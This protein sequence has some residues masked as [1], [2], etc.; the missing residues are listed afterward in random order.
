MKP[1]T[2]QT[3]SQ[4]SEPRTSAQRLRLSRVRQA[5]VTS[6][7]VMGIVASM[8]GLGMLDRAAMVLLEALIGLQML[9]FVAMVRLGF[10][11]KLRDPS[12]TAAQ[13]VG[14]S[15]VLLL[16][17]YFATYD[18]RAIMLMLILLVFAFAS[19]RYGVAGL[20]RLSGLLL[21]LVAIEQTA[22][23]VLRADPIS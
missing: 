6:V 16:G 4:P 12:M 19:Y 21:L 11:L 7:P 5:V 3:D 2:V 14:A 23:A 18:G 8:H 9:G 20:M 15:S 10:N 17:A 1:P 13:V 22:A